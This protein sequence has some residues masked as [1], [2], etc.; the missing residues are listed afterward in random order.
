LIVLFLAAPATGAF[1]LSG[2]RAIES[3]ADALADATA[4]SAVSNV[5]RGTARAAESFKDYSPSEEHFIGRAVAAE[6]LSRYQVH[7]DP[8]LT[9]YV[10][11]VGLAVVYGAPDVRQTF[12][13]YHFTILEGDELNAVSAPGGFVFLTLGTIRRARNEDELAAVL[14]HEIAHVSLRHGI[15]AIQAATRKRSGALLVQGVGE[16][17]SQVARAGG[18]G[19]EGDLVELTGLFAG[20]IQD[21]TSELL[22]KGYSR[23]SELAADELG[24]KYLAASN[25]ARSA[26]GTYL[27]RLEAEGGKGGWLGTHP[28]ARD[29]VEAL[30]SSIRKDP[31][32]VLSALP[33]RQ[34][35]FRA[36]M[37]A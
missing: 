37:G 12:S 2:C 19:R 17:A 5:F 31:P 27:S 24:A 26:L 25:Y 16:S 32:A 10:N 28:P 23:K 14:A 36:A 7:D 9:E 4:G 3:G 21:I 35:R 34:R 1:L 33:V 13:G 30:G 11:L 15:E 22:V 6:V 29:R 20:A 18:G 8:R